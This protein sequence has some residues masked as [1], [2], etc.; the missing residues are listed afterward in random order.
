MDYRRLNAITK[1]D[2]YP[3]PR[4]EELLDKI[5][6]ARYLSTMDLAKGYWQVPMSDE[7]REKTAFSSPNGLF[8]FINMPFGLSGAPATFQRMMDSILRGTDDYG[9]VY[10]DDIVIYSS[11]W[12]TH[13]N[14]LEKVFQ[15]LKDSNL[16]VKTAKCIFG[17]EDC[18][19]LGYKIG[20]GGVKPEDSKIQAIMQVEIPKTKKDVRA[21]L[22]MTGYYRRFIPN[23]ATIVGPLTELTKKHTPNHV[24]WNDQADNSFNRLKYML[25]NAPLMRNP[26]FTRT[27]ILQTDASGIG[28][29]AVLSQG[30]E[31][32]RPIAYFSR[33]LLPRERAYLTVEK[34]CLAIVLAVQHF[35]VYLM[36]RQFIIQTDHRALQWLNKFREKNARLTRWSLLLQ[37]Y[38]HLC[39]RTQERTST[40]KCRWIVKAALRAREGGRKCGGLMDFN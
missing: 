13:L 8:H 14:H 16:T 37:P 36:G 33:K 3:M 5:G 23:Y 9:G 31:E 4:I 6:T 1:F 11:D 35:K 19:Y 28:V 10:L 7:D 29:G 22:G 32:D 21:F 38:I 2:A 18:V 39:N 24:L 25:I 17:A 34:E 20:K 27:F 40:C 12:K 30:E 26:D 15:R